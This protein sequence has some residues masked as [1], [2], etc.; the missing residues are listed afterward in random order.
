MASFVYSNN[1]STTLAVAITS[2]TQTTVT[3][4]SD[5]QV[6]TIPGGSYW[7]VTMNDAA[8]GLVYE[9]MYATAASGA[10]LTVLRGQ[11]GTTA[12]TWLAGTDRIYGAATAAELAQFASGGASGT[13]AITTSATAQ[14]KAGALTVAGLTSTAGIA[15][16]GA[17]T[18]ATSGLFSGN[19]GMQNLSAASTQVT[20]L[21]VVGN[22]TSGA[23][24]MG[25]G[26]SNSTL[27]YGQSTANVFTLGAPLAVIAKTAAAYVPPLT[28]ATGTALAST[29]HIVSG[30]GSVTF[31]TPTTITLSDSATFASSTS[32]QVVCSPTENL[33]GLA[34]S[35]VATKSSG[36]VFTVVA[37]NSG[38]TSGSVT[39]DWIAIGA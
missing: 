6:P 10:V 39:F 8:T 20:L 2:T 31:G 37:F 9:I 13:T 19:V 32:Y 4:S 17:L 7:A 35:F 3:L 14:A 36:S 27:D 15:V 18:G 25:G 38:E 11:E 34:V 28:N 29:S 1:F 23:I 12:Q 33:D 21:Q 24:A 22:S 16:G 26:S 5:A 30:S